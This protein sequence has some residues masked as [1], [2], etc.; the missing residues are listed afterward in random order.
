MAQRLFSRPVSVRSCLFSSTSTPIVAPG[1]SESQVSDEL[2]E[3]LKAGWV[4]DQPRS[5]IEK[6]YYFKTYTKCQKAGS[7]HVHW[8]THHPRGLTLLD[9]LMA[10]YCDEQSASIGTVDQNQSKKC[11]PAPA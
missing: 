11:H 1:V 6:S 3:L 9:T 10:R 7:V 8:T 2:R 4:L 5:G